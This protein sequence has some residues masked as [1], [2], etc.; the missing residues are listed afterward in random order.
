M[1]KNPQP[2]QAGIVVKSKFPFN[3]NGDNQA[4][5]YTGQNNAATT[6]DKNDPI[7]GTE[8]AEVSRQMV[9]RTIDRSPKDILTL[10][11]SLIAAESVYY[12]NQERLFDL[13]EDVLRDT[14]LKGIIRKL[15]AQI[16]NKNLLF[17]KNGEPVPGMDKI[18][19][20]KVFKDICREIL[21]TP[22]WGI[23]GMEFVPG[24][25]IKFNL[26][27]KK[28]I[29]IKT[30]KITYEQ[31]GLTEGID[32]TKAANIWILGDEHVIGGNGST[33]DM[34]LLLIC[35]YWV[36]LKK[37]VI[38]DWAQY[39]QIFG[40]PAIVIKYKGFDKQ[41]KDAADT[42][43]DNIGSSN[44]V[45][46]PE[47]M[48]VEFVEAKNTSGSGGAQDTF[49][50]AANEELSILI[51]GNTETTGHGKNGTGAKSQTHSEQ[52][53]EIIRDAMD[54]AIGQ[55]NSDRFMSI[56]K[57]YGLPVEGGE[58]EFDKEVDIAYLEKK[59]PIDIAFI[60][61]GFPVSKKYVREHYA[62]PEPENEADTFLYQG[63]QEDEQAGTNPPKPGMGKPVTKRKP[64]ALSVSADMVSRA[65]LNAMLD[66]KFKAFF[67]HA[68]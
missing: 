55:L 26:V 62:L 34:G 10:Q 44:R 21:W 16:I 39:I 28:H 42:V 30:Q 11:T 45:T 31:F 8:V 23:N 57:S 51:L 29:K 37:G 33:H 17:T 35:G 43:L 15:I 40:S 56:L 67:G 6:Q 13:Y 27:P 36:L 66:E 63:G 38:S 3:K 48:G 7:E 64:K 32:Y 4:Y 9:V 41:A 46:I 22:F 58:F 18:I 60:T 52:Q 19:K 24:E 14:F 53:L 5:G 54:Y 59:M 65:E 1:N 47:E 49:R 12:P 2:E 25:K 61:A 68:L 20:S 50:Q